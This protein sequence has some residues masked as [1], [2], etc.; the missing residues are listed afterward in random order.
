MSDDRHRARR[1]DIADQPTEQLD[2]D[3]LRYFTQPAD[4]KPSTRHRR[5][6]AFENPAEN[7]PAENATEITGSAPVSS[8]GRGPRTLPDASAA[9]E[10]DDLQWED[11]ADI[12]QELPLTSGEYRDPLRSAVP[13]RARPQTVA[14]AEAATTSLLADEPPA[15]PP[16][17]PQPR[18]P[19]RR[20]SARVRRRRRVALA[21]VLTC[22]LLLVLAVGYVGLRAVGMFGPSDNDYSN[23]SG[24]ADVI[25]DIPANST[26]SDFG[27][28]LHD[29]D[30]V[31]SVGAFVSAADG[32]TMSGG[33]YKLRTQIPAATAVEMMTDG[34]AHRVGRMVVPE[35]LQLD[36]KTGID[37][38]ITPGIFQMISDATSVTINGEQ[39]GVSIAQLE[40]A[41][42]DDTPEQLGVPEWARPTVEKLTGD[43]RRVEGL[44]APGTWETIDP[45]HSATQILHDL[46]QASALR[47][48]Q[49]GL[50][51]ESGSSLTP[52][53]TLVAA[54][55]VEREVASPEDYAKV[56]RVILNRLAKG[57][58]LEMDSTANY[59]AQVTN[60]DVHGEAYRA[61][62]AWNTYRIEGLPVTP[63]GAVGQSALEATLHPADGRWLYFVTIDREGT[64]LFADT[65]EE[66]KK[67]R[68]KACESGL[69]TTGCS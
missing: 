56:A 60:I 39:I 16:H 59:T 3:R 51:G 32:Q 21:V 30:V 9:T 36:N 54:S 34:T 2:L 15:A 13:H 35:G 26:L 38:K 67:N 8:P 64:T 68:E 53:E 27:V 5:R 61:D 11:P 40:Q 50:L 52:Y 41:A 24:T 22:M 33:F 37:G 7:R 45:H 43:H 23:A 65:F 44:I 57:Q 47:F 20:G 63:I 31:G 55:V 28:I 62:T 49:W 58:R 48:E 14:S 18:K 46:V 1:H 19:A 4:G 6:R 25:V 17:P 66:H 10:L 12:G 29:A 42:A 69:L